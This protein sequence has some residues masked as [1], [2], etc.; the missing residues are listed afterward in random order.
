LKQGAESGSVELWI[1]H[2]GIS[3]SFDFQASTDGS[4]WFD[5]GRSVHA[6]F[7][8][9]GLVPGTLYWFRHRALTRDGVGDWSDPITFRVV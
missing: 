7:R 1:Q 2:P 9:T 8:L 4:H 6:R 3:S 5:V